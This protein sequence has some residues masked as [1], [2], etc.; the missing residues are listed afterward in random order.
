MRLNPEAIGQAVRSIAITA[1][2]RLTAINPPIQITKEGEFQSLVLLQ[3]P[4]SEEETDRP[5][6]SLTITV[7]HAPVRTVRINGALNLPDKQ[8]REENIDPFNLVVL[9]DNLDPTVKDPIETRP[10]DVVLGSRFLTSV[11][12][13]N[14]GGISEIVTEALTTWPVRQPDTPATE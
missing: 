4:G 8:G 3:P 14:P 1:S 9:R 6:G 5:Q 11:L 10:P 13:H 12:A 7:V 2:N